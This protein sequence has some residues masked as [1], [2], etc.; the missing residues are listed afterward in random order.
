MLKKVLFG[1]VMGVVAISVS[2]CT[3]PTTTSGEVTNSSPN[4][5]LEAALNIADDLESDAPVATG[6]LADKQTASSSTPANNT[7]TMKTLD[8]QEDLFAQYTGAIIKTNYGDITVKLYGADSPVTVNNFLNLAKSGFYNGIKFHRVIKD[9]MI[10]GGDPLTKGTDVS[11][12]G[13]GGPGYKFPDE[14][15]S[16]KLIVG[17]LAM[18]NSGANTNG[19]QFFIV[20]APATSWLDGKHTNFGEVTDGMDVVKKIE[21]VETVG[22]GVYDRPAKDVIINSIELIK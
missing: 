14:F 9:F 2:A 20:T 5:E 7:T 17:S 13:T 15:N 19:S 21:A 6:T 8:K 10:Q 11:L 4:L 3:S 1:L 22:P 16:H 18:A 12:Y